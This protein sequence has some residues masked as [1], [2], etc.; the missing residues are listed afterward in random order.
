[1]AI[2][3]TATKINSCEDIYT[4]YRVTPEQVA[5][6]TMIEQTSPTHQIFYLVQSASD[7]TT[8]YKVQYT[9]ERGLQCLSWDGGRTCPASAE[10]IPCWHKR[11]ALCA[12]AIYR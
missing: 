11:A 7:P 6:C 8:E 4:A 3:T 5:A 12:Y 9:R 1:M 2:T 10:G